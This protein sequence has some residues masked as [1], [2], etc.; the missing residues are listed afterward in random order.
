MQKVQDALNRK[1]KPSPRLDVDGVRGPKTTAALRRFQG[2][3][4]PRGGKAGPRTLQA[5][6]VKC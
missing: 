5:L 1:L 4:A 2:V 6:G 3:K